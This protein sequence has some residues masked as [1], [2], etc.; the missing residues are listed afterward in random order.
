MTTREEIIE[1]VIGIEAG[2]VNHPGDGGGRTIYGI[3]EGHWPEMWKHGTPARDQAVPFYI[4]EFWNPLRCGDF[5][6]M[7][8]AAELFE[9]AVNCGKHTAAGY[10]QKA[11]NSLR[12]PE[13]TT[14]QVDG[15]VG[16]FTLKAV[17]QMCERYEAALF[18]GC[19]CLQGAEYLKVKPATFNRGWLGKRI[20]SMKG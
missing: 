3:S 2:Y 11:Y 8:I 10:L 9:A 12:P 20:R 6:S 14:L 7:N 17:N 1:D 5:D 4:R 19:N 16:P 15:V 13:W 18:N